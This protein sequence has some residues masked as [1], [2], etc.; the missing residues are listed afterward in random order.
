MRIL[1]VTGYF[2]PEGGSGSRLAGELAGFLA[3]AG[4]AV[5]VL[6]PTP[7]YYVDTRTVQGQQGGLGR[8]PDGHAGP[9]SFAE[10]SASLLH[11]I[12]DVGS[13][14]V[15]DPPVFAAGDVQVVRAGFPVP[16]FLP[17]KAARGI[18]HLVRPFT[19]LPAG[20]RLPRPDVVYG[21]SLQ[22]AG[23]V[24]ATGLARWFRRSAT[25]CRNAARD[26]SRG[27]GS[28]LRRTPCEEDVFPAERYRRSCATPRL[29]FHIEDLFPDNAVDTG[30]ISRGPVS[31]L[32]SAGMGVLLRHADRVFVHAPGLVSRLAE[33]GSLRRRFPTG[34]TTA[35]WEPGPRRRATG[36]FLVREDGA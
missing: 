14:S 30:I 21:F 1:L 13:T 19:L 12:G 16:R 7:N 8:H 5:T 36:C 11:P 32:L 22:P 33:R 2:P 9:P 31:G 25:D 4:H 29:F 15:S 34:W 23:V 10:P 6:A 26:E 24:A 3:S 28:S 35:A 27:A 20:L 18:E 17:H